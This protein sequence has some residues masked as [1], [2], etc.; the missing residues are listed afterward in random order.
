MQ[1]PRHDPTP[2]LTHR[3]L[4]GKEIPSPSSRGGK[5]SLT[6]PLIEQAITLRRKSRITHL[7]S[8]GLINALSIPT[9]GPQAHENSRTQNLPARSTS[10]IAMLRQQRSG[11][12]WG[13]RK[14]PR[15]FRREL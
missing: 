6:S 10:L 2:R 5:M 4:E 13:V 11:P 7:E 14:H 15:Q 3:G 9:G 12:L 8:I 1:D